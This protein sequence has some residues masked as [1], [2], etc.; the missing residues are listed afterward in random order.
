MNEKEVSVKTDGEKERGSQAL[1]ISRKDCSGNIQCSS[2]G[3]ITMSP[4]TSI[5][6]SSHMEQQ[7][8]Y[9]HG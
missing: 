9:R 8:I 6:M 1:V 3:S 2:V 4:R 7:I 5:I